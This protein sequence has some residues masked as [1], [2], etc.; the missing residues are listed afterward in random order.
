M[1]I[2]AGLSKPA[3][4]ETKNGIGVFKA[5]LAQLAKELREG[6]SQLWS[7]QMA[8]RIE[9]GGIRFCRAAARPRHSSLIDPFL[10]M[11]TGSFWRPNYF[12]TQRVRRGTV[13][14]RFWPIGTTCLRIRRPQAIRDTRLGI[15]RSVP[16]GNEDDGYGA[17]I[18]LVKSE[19]KPNVQ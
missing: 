18:L 8:T 5:T 10:P 7:S 2:S 14:A 15:W 3:A 9:F 16:R 4:V 12:T 17:P 19:A 13:D 6:R 1:A 11:T